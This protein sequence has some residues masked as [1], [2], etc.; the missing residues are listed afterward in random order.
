MN[1]EQFKTLI[2]T[3]QKVRDKYSALYDLG[4]DALNY[5]EDFQ[6]VINLLMKCAFKEEGED[7]ISWYLY[8]RTGFDGKVLE[9]WDENSNPICYNLESLWDTVKPYR[10][11]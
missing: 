1:F 8:E 7:W 2:E 11:Q 4:I 5:E 10:K 9:A 6:K 3:L